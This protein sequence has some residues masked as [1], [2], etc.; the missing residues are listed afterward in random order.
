VKGKRGSTK[1]E[2]TKG[3]KGKIVDN[4]S[5]EDVDLDE[6]KEKVEKKI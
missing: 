4:H 6:G 3:G 1:Q 5:E 2:K